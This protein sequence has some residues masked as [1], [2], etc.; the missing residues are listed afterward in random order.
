MT[1]EAMRLIER[2]DIHHGVKFLVVHGSNKYSSNDEEF[3]P[4]AIIPTS[5]PPVPTVFIALA[6][7]ACISALTI[8]PLVKECLTCREEG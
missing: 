5:P 1:L 8:S 6:L 3:L 7:L 4:L 2:R